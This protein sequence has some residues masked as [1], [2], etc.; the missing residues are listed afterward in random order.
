MGITRALVDGT[1]SRVDAECDALGAMA[2][3]RGSGLW[4][5]I[6]EVESRRFE[7][8]QNRRGDG[9]KRDRQVEWNN[10]EPLIF[11]DLARAEADEF[12]LWRQ[13]LQVEVQKGRSGHLPFLRRGFLQ[14]SFCQGTVHLLTWVTLAA[15]RSAAAQLHAAENWHSGELLSGVVLIKRRLS[16][17]ERSRQT[18]NLS[19]PS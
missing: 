6:D 11:D 13:N 18:S 3:R 1:Q 5:E 4:E 16:V 15:T 17:F 8:W 14:R 9:A 10:S 12:V 19:K 7:V 2:N